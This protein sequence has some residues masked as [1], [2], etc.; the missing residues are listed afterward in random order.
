MHYPYEQ[1]PDAGTALEI[2]EGLR[3]IRMPLPFALDHVNL[4]LIADHDVDADVD[5]NTSTSVTGW[6][7]VDT[8]IALDGVKAHWQQLLTQYHLTRQ[9]VTHCHP[10]HLG[11]AGWLEQQSG[12]RLW[13]TQGEFAVAHL[14]RAGVDGYGYPAA[15]AF[16]VRHGLDAERA[17]TF[18]SRGNAFLRGVPTM[19]HTY[20]RLRDHDEIKIGNHT[21]RVIIGYGHAPEHA[22]LYCESLRILIS[23]DML[24]PRI[25]TN[26]HVSAATPDNDSLYE[27]L[28]SLERFLPLPPDTLVLPSHGKPFRGLH[29]RV[30]QLQQHHIRR[31]DALCAAC[32]TA[33]KSAADL[34]PALFDRDISDPHQLQFAMGETIAH[35]NYLEHQQRIERLDDGQILRYRA[36]RT[37]RP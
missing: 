12:A 34:L 3:W 18:E 14:L 33:P 29:E 27:Y 26:I 13:M 21:W 16:F 28:T 5:A 25:T 11:L 36:S 4:W 15:L 8:G 7:A 2:V 23:G 37:S 10:D 6:A 31:C 9:I 24:L 17:A 19:P 30:E 20:T 35:L 22:A 1:L 32:T